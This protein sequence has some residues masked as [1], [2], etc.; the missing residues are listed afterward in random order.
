MEIGFIGLG[1][2]GAG[3]AENL[4]KAGHRLTVWNRSPAPVQAL[5][6][7]GAVAA[8]GPEE[9]VGGDVLFS[10]LA[11]DA[12]L[13]AVG[14]DGALLDGAAKGLVHVNLAT[15]STGLAQELAKAHAAR[16]LGYVSAP[17][18]GRPDAA[19]SAQLE[20]VA[21]GDKAAL[22]KVAPLLAQIGRRV[23]IA[24]DKPE[25]ANL[26]KIAG[27]FLIASALETMSEVFTLLSKGG[28]NPVLF[29]DV[30]TDALFAG[31]IY[32]NYGRLVLE[33]KFTPPGFAL[34]LGLKDVRLAEDAAKGLS[35]SLPVSSVV[36]GHLEEAL[37][38]GLGEED[39]TAVSKVIEKKA[40]G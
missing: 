30:M 27:N 26:F 19:A 34:A 33:K 37:S 5:A 4:I 39:W 15:I 11:N 18:F 6:A 31:R 23:E 9:T 35:M 32:K 7:K 17:V 38:A 2:M 20:V 36:R 21:A 8:K 29:H 13:R 40:Q 3:V 25:Q 10:M 24:G 14:L 12:A 28:V 1:A 22:D 16:G